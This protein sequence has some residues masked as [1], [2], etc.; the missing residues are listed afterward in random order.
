MT[1]GS[2]R[3]TINKMYVYFSSGFELVS[4]YPFPTTITITPRALLTFNC[5]LTKDKPR[6]SLLSLVWFYGTSTIVGY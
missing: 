6:I 2:F 5:S 3:N 1:S 4:P